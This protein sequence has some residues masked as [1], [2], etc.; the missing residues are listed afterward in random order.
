MSLI[1]RIPEGRALV[2]YLKALTDLY[3]QD[4]SLLV[5]RGISTPGR[6]PVSPADE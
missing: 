3:R 2:N 1:S 5:R 4:G 6:D